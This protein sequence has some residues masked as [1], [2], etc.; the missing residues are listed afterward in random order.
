MTERQKQAMKTKQKLIENAMIMIEETGFDQ[1]K[2]QDLCNRAGVSVGTFYHYFKNLDELIQ[3]SYLGFD[4]MLEEELLNKKFSN[5]KE[6]ISFIIIYSIKQLTSFGVNATA[7]TFKQ[8]MGASS[9]LMVDKHR[10]YY[11]KLLSYLQ[12]GILS[13]EFSLH[14]SIEET[15]DWLLRTA[16]GTAI[17]WCLHDGKYDVIH[18]V[19]LEVSTL[20]EILCPNEKK[21]DTSCT[22]NPNI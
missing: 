13:H 6:A 7:M 11:Q 10:F 3:E 19:T 22:F 9:R 18:M 16:R 4:D 1:L 14:Y 20:L 12:N 15:A 8:Q 5:Y 17:D 21:E 2:M